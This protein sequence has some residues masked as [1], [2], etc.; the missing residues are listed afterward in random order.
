F[1][2]DAI[3]SLQNQ[4]GQADIEETT[5]PAVEET[6]AP[7]VEETTAP[8]VEETTAP[9]VE[10][11]AAP[12]VEET[13]APAV[14]ETAAPKL[15]EAS[16]GIVE[17]IMSKLRM[18]QDL[19]MQN[20]M[21]AYAMLGIVALGIITAI[22]MRM[23]RA[24]SSSEQDEGFLYD[25][26]DASLPPDIAPNAP[27]P[28]MPE[29]FTEENTDPPDEEALEVESASD[30]QEEEVEEEEEEDDAMITVDTYLAFEQYEQ[31][32]EA[33]R[34]MIAEK[35]NDPDLHIKLLEIF[36]TS[37]NRAAYEKAAK[38]TQKICENDTE[39]W[40]MAL[41]MWS[42]MS[43][44]PLFEEGD[45]EDDAEE[46]STSAAAGGMVD[47][48]AG[49]DS[50]EEEASLDLDLGFGGSDESQSSDDDVDASIEIEEMLGEDLLDVTAASH[51]T[52]ENDDSDFDL[53]ATMD[54]NKKNPE[55]ETAD[56]TNLDNLESTTD[57]TAL[58]P[59]SITADPATPDSGDQDDPDTIDFDLNDIGE[60]GNESLEE[61]TE[62]PVSEEHEMD[63]I[64]FDISDISPAGEEQEDPAPDKPQTEK[65][66]LE[67]A[68]LEFVD[69]DEQDE[70][71]LPMNTGLDLEESEDGVEEVSLEAVVDDDEIA[72]DIMDNTVDFRPT[73]E[74]EDS[75]LE[76]SSESSNAS[77]DGDELTL[78]LPQGASEDQ[79]DDSEENPW[80]NKIDLARTYIE[81][82]QE[83]N[84]RELLQSVIESPETTDDHK[85]RAQELLD[86][87]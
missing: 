39:K 83:D 37:G 14:E 41:A 25:E 43:N 32:E 87:I 35:P 46:V 61:N 6:T 19:I 40:N 38:E 73:L 24:R 74:E 2:D 57:P 70:E 51:G 79:N 86:K 17:Q 60:I 81:F 50:S 47:L 44:R 64:E 68:L 82:G 5:T 63:A 23:R 59:E 9:A 52:L 65:D 1:K 76:S 53:V 58:E 42:E 48:T 15:E 30:L 3:A 4:L 66:S 27:P 75:P 72:D 84:A 12:A 55:S 13:A 80:S 18:I 31:A 26:E 77:L 33:V 28:P 10:E 71:E 29:S 16:Q 21:I 49:E 56:P 54:F 85:S 11:T 8:A 45:D 7:A 67:G 62:E 22:A 20:M 36:F 69:E 34:A 78:V